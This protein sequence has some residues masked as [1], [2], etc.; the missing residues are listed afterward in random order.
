MFYRF[1]KFIRFFHRGNK[2]LGRTVGR[3][4]ESLFYTEGSGGKIR[5]PHRIEHLF[6]I[7]FASLKNENA[8]VLTFVL[9]IINRWTS[10]QLKL[11]NDNTR[12]SQVILTFPDAVL[13]YRFSYTKSN[14]PSILLALY[15]F[16]VI[17]LVFRYRQKRSD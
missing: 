17:N 15:S 12:D 13:C 8:G 10:S 2:L 3:Y 14:L 16:Q 5:L 4:Y 7:I 11:A 1:S 9:E 6:Q